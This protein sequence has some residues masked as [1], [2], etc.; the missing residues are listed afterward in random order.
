L[1]GVKSSKP[2]EEELEEQIIIKS[3]KDFY[4]SKFGEEE[5]P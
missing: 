1:I 2:T 3:I 5:H 4:T